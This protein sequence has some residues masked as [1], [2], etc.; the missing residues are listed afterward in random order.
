MTCSFN[1]CYA[2][3]MLG[4]YNSV[5]CLRLF[6]CLPMPPNAFVRSVHLWKRGRPGT[7]N[8]CVENAMSDK[9][10]KIVYGVDEEL[11]QQQ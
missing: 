3:D 1:V 4:K 11:D 6:V 10:K 5:M 2:P 8:V 7:I 9:P